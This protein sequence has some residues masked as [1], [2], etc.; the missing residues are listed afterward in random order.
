MAIVSH[1]ITTTAQSP[2]RVNAAY[3]FTDHTGGTVKLSKLVGVGFDTEADALAMYNGISRAQAASEAAQSIEKLEAGADPVALVLNVTHATSKSI[4]KKLIFHMM[5]ERDPFI[6][7][8]L[9]PLIVYLRAELTG[10]QLLAFL[11]LTPAQGVRLNTR[12]NA[13]LD[14]K[15]ALLSADANREDIE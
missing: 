4:A 13:I 11:D 6:V 5:R 3:I 12:I 15:A 7:I 14:N 10:A 1:A 8:I 9:E 2:T